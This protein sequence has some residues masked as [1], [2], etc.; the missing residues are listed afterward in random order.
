MEA[1]GF[2]ME[3]IERIVAAAPR[4]VDDGDLAAALAAARTTF[5][6]EA[7]GVIYEQYP[8]SPTAEAL[9]RELVGGIR[10]MRKAMDEHRARAGEGGQGAARMGP[11]GGGALPRRAGRALRVP[12][13]AEG[14]NGLAGR[15]P[16]ADLPRAR[17]RAR[18][19]RAVPDHPD[20][21][22]G[23][24]APGG[25]VPSLR[26]GGLPMNR[27]PA[28]AGTFYPAN[29]ETLRREVLACLGAERGDE[30]AVALLAPH[31]GYIYSGECAGRTYAQVR[32]PGLVVALG[33]NHTGF[34]RPLAIMEEGTWETPLGPVP[35]DGPLARRLRELDPAIE[36]DPIA[37]AR[38]H[39]LEVQLP[40][41]LALRPDVRVVPI[42][43]G[44]DRLSELLA[45]GDAVAEAVRGA[46]ERVL[47]VVSSDMS[48]YI[49]FDL[50]RA[51]D[52]KAIAKLEALDAEGLHRTIEREGITMCGYCPAVAGLRAARALGAGSGRLVAYTSS[53]DRTG[54]YA[55]VV[56]Y[57][58]L[59]FH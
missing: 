19:A 23:G 8:T 29:P 38:E 1:L 9:T 2:L 57:A 46:G 4:A 48:H 58:G 50:A 53:G 27:K 43:V 16:P 34:G 52:A 40:F 51:L 12:P 3:G 41:L 15:A 32:V 31:A 13:R 47:I 24:T 11:R 10:S 7:K 45:L 54:D 30:E 55:S 36:A 37:H 6:S 49:P 5:E 28:V 35:L 56:A 20:L 33:P 59:T 44:T 42:C 21:T 26:E 14:R 25:L 18:G 39:S 17:A 22:R